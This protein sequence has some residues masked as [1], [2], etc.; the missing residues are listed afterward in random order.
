MS[1]NKILTGMINEQKFKTSSKVSK[2]IDSA[3]KK[4]IEQKK[5]DQ[6]QKRKVLLNTNYDT[7]KIEIDLPPEIIENLTGRAEQL[8]IPIE[9]MYNQIF[10]L[11]LK[12]SEQEHNYDST[13]EVAGQSQTEKS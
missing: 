3:Y 2:Q 8:E 9:K 1:F 4:L 5:K 10:F 12:Q 11:G 7:S 6:Q 13:Q